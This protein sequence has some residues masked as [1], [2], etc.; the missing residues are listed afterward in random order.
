M[1]YKQDSFYYYLE[2]IKLAER[3]MLDQEHQDH[4]RSSGHCQFWGTT[5]DLLNQTCKGEA[6]CAMSK[7]ALQVFLSTGLG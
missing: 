3:L 2:F 5:P 4:L 6:E 7:Q 1:E